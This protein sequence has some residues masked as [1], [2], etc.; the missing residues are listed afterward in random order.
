MTVRLH[1]QMDWGQYASATS[2]CCGQRSTLANPTRLAP[3]RCACRLIRCFRALRCC[4]VMLC[5]SMLSPQNKK[6]FHP[7]KGTEVPCYHPIS[8]D[9]HKAGLLE[10]AGHRPSILQ[11]GNGCTR[12]VSLFDL[13]A[14]RPSS[15]SNRASP[16]TMR[17]LS[18]PFLLL[19]SSLH[20]LLFC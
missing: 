18:G 6:N 11:H 8:P 10:Y 3:R 5:R 17:R 1:G 16:P 7:R 13:P 19:Y 2:F 20:C 14:Q 15:R 9:S 4:P 12:A